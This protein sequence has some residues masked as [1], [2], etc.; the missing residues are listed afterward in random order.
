MY[1]STN[2]HL[3]SACREINIALWA[4]RSA[5]I[6]GGASEEAPSRY[7]ALIDLPADEVGEILGA[8]DLTDEERRAIR[9]N[10]GTALVLVLDPESAKDTRVLICEDEHL[11]GLYFDALASA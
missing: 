4:N 5:E 1:V 7:I 9:R 11:A 8:V 2:Q 10:V 6:R 3:V